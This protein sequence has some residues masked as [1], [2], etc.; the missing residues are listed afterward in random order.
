M[1]PAS[2]A[3][4]RSSTIAR[5]T[6]PKTPR[7]SSSE[8]FFP[9]KAMIWSSADSA[10]RMPPSAPRAIA[11]SASGAASTPSALQIFP[12]CP[13]RSAWEILRRSKR[14]QRDWIVP[15]TLSG[16]VVAKMNL[17]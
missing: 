4:A 12:S 5:E 3:S 8:I 7:T 17:T 15:M 13:T 14:W 2:T 16:S 1:S 9:V 6:S 10:S 11:S